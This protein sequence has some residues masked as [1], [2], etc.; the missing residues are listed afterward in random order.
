MDVLTEETFCA[1]KNLK[2][3]LHHGADASLLL[4]ILPG[5]IQRVKKQARGSGNE[6][7]LFWILAS[8]PDISRYCSRRSGVMYTPLALGW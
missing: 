6:R 2:L 5:N 3:Q 4:P 7:I 1:Y 8:R